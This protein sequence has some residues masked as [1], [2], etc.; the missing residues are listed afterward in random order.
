M[1]K[2][3]FPQWL[4]WWRTHRGWVTRLCPSLQSVFQIFHRMK[5]S[6]SVSRKCG[7]TTKTPLLVSFP[8]RTTMR[9]SWSYI[10]HISCASH[11]SK[12]QTNPLVQPFPGSP[13]EST[14]TKITAPKYDSQM[15]SAKTEIPEMKEPQSLKPRLFESVSTT[16]A[17]SMKKHKKHRVW[18]VMKN[19]NNDN[20]NKMET[21]QKV[22]RNK[23]DS[24]IASPCFSL[25]T[26]WPGNNFCVK[27]VFHFLGLKAEASSFVFL[28]SLSISA[29]WQQQPCHQWCANHLHNR[30]DGQ[31]DLKGCLQ[32]SF[33]TNFMSFMGFKIKVPSLRTI[34]PH[35]V[36][37]EGG[38]HMTE[39]H[40][41]TW[42]VMSQMN[43]LLTPQVDWQ[44]SKKV[45]AYEDA[46]NGR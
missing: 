34:G 12:P 14:S 20:H 42:R 40:S 28:G 32:I 3:P 23:C 16:P 33:L 1:W 43:I 37:G 9:H 7:A 45:A 31:N 41:N 2:S 25:F 10:V 8:R 15:L 19:I 27:V 11:H 35:E 18:N 30:I 39:S 17:I 38:I 46:S 21:G 13:K 26:F 29:K 5:V 22:K 4:P 44:N 6:K 24:I 36:L